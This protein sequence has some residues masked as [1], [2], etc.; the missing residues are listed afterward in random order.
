[1]KK[2]K[3]TLVLVI[4]STVSFAGIITVDN[5]AGSGAN[6][7]SIN[8]AMSAASNGDTLY[9]H[10]STVN[11]GNIW[12]NKSLVFIG[13]GH[14]P[15]YTGGLGASINQ[16][17]MQN[18]SS[19]TKI[20][21]LIFT[22]NVVVQNG[23]TTVHNIEI[24]NNY[25]ISGARAINGS[26]LTSNNWLIEG[27]VIVELTGSSNHAIIDISTGASAN[28][29][30][31]NNFIQSKNSQNQTFIF[32][33]LNSTIIVENNIILHLNTN[34]IFINSIIGGI[35]RNNIFWIT[36][37]VVTDISVNATNV[38]FSN[39]ITYHSDGTLTP[40]PGNDNIDNTDPE[41][42]NF[43]ADNQVWDYA[44]NFE[45]NASSPGHN[46]G[47]DGTDLGIYGANFPFQKNGYPQDFPRLQFF[48]VSNT[49]VPQGGVIEISIN[50]TRAGL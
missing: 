7:T 8:S 31:R 25:I 41:F 14:H 1:M 2:F 42:L 24:I 38:V 6:F 29:I 18:G 49:V 4:I 27:N 16:F 35:F 34:D 15:E 36:R 11:Y 12:I 47:T 43:P 9:I 28:W 19:N 10:P 22:S 44:N 21:G 13:P 39:N 26:G 32:G 45:L 20:I 46:T 33:N 23:Q 17:I 30:I 40:L 48:D 50:A 5:N 3:L 37:N